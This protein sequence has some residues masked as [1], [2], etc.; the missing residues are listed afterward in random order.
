LSTRA[1]IELDAEATRNN[2]GIVARDINNWAG[3][4][5]LTYG[6]TDRVK[7]YTDLQLYSQ[8]YN[9]F[10]GAPINRQRYL[11]GVLFDVSE[12]PN[13]E[14]NHPEQTRPSQR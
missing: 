2:S 12:H 8:T 14:A 6:L 7:V 5:K 11:A 4:L 3:R 13:R 1:G 9:V 10:V